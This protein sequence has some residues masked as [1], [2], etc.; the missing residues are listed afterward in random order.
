MAT[1]RVNRSIIYNRRAQYD[2]QLLDTFEAGLSL[3]GAEV[4]SLRSGNAS[5]SEAFGKVDG[6]EIFLYN[7][8]I[9]PYPCSQEVFDPRRKRKLLFH[10]REIAHITA[11]LSQKGLALVPVKVYFRRGWAKVEIA[12]GKGKRQYDKREALRRRETEKEIR[13]HIQR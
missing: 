3:N 5:L 9:A 8:Y 4:K 1:K 6:G 13:R 10:K 2:Y 7:M 11:A 12:L